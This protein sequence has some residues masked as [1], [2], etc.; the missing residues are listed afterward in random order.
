MV[1]KLLKVLGLTTLFSLLTTSSAWAGG[2]IIPL[3]VGG[4]TAAAV[5]TAG[6]AV[7][8]LTVLATA[9]LAGVAA[10]AVTHV[11]MEAMTPSF[12][13]PDYS[14]NAA[15]GATQVNTGILLN[16]TGTNNPIPVVYGYRKIG[17]SRV[18]VQTTGDYNQHLYVVMAFC[19]GEIGEFDYLFLDD[20]IVATPLTIKQ[21]EDGGIHD[22]AYSKDSRLRYQLQTGTST[23][24]PPSWFTSA[25]PDWSSSHR[26]KGLAIGYFKFTW[27]RPDVN[28]SG[29]DQQE[30]VDANPYTGIPKIQV[31][32]QG[33]KTPRATDY[34]DG[35]TTEYDGM[36]KHYTRNPAD[37]LLDYLMNPTYGRSL[38]ANRIGFTSFNTA[39]TKYNTSVT[40]STGESGKYLQNDA[41]IHTDRTMLE[42]VQTFLQNMRSGM[43]YVQGKFQLKLLDT[44]HASDPTNTTPVITFAVT[45]DHIVG[46]IVIEGKGHRDQYNQIRAVFPNPNNNW[47]VD[48]VVYPAVGSATD[49]TLLAEDNNKRFMKE[50]SLEHI[51]EKNQAVDVAKVVLERSRKK[52]II[53]FTTTAELHEAQVGDIITVTYDSLGLSAKQF[54]IT[55][56]Q[57]TADYTVN[58]VAEE[59]DATKYNFTNVDVFVPRPTPISVTGSNNRPNS[60][61][62]NSTGS[63]SVLFGKPAVGFGVVAPSI[64]S[65]N[66]PVVNVGSITSLTHERS[67]GGP[68]YDQY[69]SFATVVSHNGVNI[70][71]IKYCYIE[72][73][74]SG[75]STTIPQDSDFLNNTNALMGRLRL[76][77]LSTGTFET[78][79]RT[80]IDRLAP[81]GDKPF[82]FVRMIHEAFDGTRL[83][84]FPKSVANP[85]PSTQ[86]GHSVP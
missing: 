70:N 37:H 11:A 20:N 49:T 79:F 27:I 64:V 59:H 5:V 58:I 69:N 84:S 3:L 44:G 67:F 77:K 46:S 26:L 74:G 1:T 54:R 63:K 53:S 42:N 50:I 19:E 61:V 55:S 28:A 56:H 65:P 38:T 6:V 14:S 18:Y 73:V 83:I 23:Q 29:E 41:V 82:I 15:S 34:V 51:T 43:P 36:T 68:N 75:S 13:I 10:A 62:S 81:T 85:Q 7:A 76:T 2:F 78:S 80:T 35:N 8:G 72:A 9:V 16:K 17:G 25:N 32:V 30:V 33:K 22:V 60:W 47:E 45:E 52:K 71:N 31:I 66:S 40:Y 48:E 24:S 21:N 12:D 4:A 86:K 39:A 57:L